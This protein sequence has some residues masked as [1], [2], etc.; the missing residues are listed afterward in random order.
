MTD[1]ARDD[2]GALSRRVLD[3]QTDKADADDEILFPDDVLPGVGSQ[4][5]SLRE[6]LAK[7]GIA[8]FVVLLILNSLDELEAAALAVLAPEIRDSFGVG[9][10]VIVFLGAASVSFVFLGALPMGWLADRFRRGPVIGAASLAFGLFSLLSGLAR[11]VVVFFFARL[12]TG[13]AKS[14]TMP[15]HNSL[16]A[17]QYPIGVRGRIASLTIMSGRTVSIISPVLV[18]GIAAVVSWRWTYYTLWIPVAVVAVLAFRLPEPVRGQWEKNDVLGKAGDAVDPA[19]ISLEAAFARLN[20]V[21]TLRA[22][23]LGFAA[24]GF[25]LFS[26]PV[27]TS[28]FLE[29]EYGLGPLGRG[30]LTTASGVGVIAIMPFVGRWFDRFYRQNPTRSMTLIGALILPSALLL[31]IQFNMPNPWLFAVLDVPGALMMFAAFAMVGPLM[32]AVVPYRLR[33]I[34]SSLATL[35]I[36]FIGAAGGGLLSAMVVD[37]S[38]PKTTILVLGLPSTIVGGA[39]M[40]NGARH[41]RHDLSRNVAEILEEQAEHDRQLESPEHIPALQLADIDFSYGNVQVLFDVGFEV[42]KGETL[43]LL[44]TNGAGKSTIL[45]VIAG[46]GTPERGVVRLGGRTIT[47]STPEQRTNMGI[48]TLLGGNGVWAPLSV[49]HNLEMGAH[50]LRDDKAE[51]QRRI[52]HALELF[53]E[54]RSRLDD[55]ADSL[56]GGQ[57]QMLALARTLLCPPEVLLIDELSLGLAP[58]AVAELMGHIER[59]QSTGQTIVIVEQSLNIALELADRAVFIEKGQVRFEGPA[60]ELAERDDLVRAVFLGDEGG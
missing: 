35:Y 33:G 11:N 49:R 45:R 59:L 39:F 16:I 31:P 6:G 10:G 37:A 51:R 18:G 53:P 60:S 43:A 29:D 42:R 40:L 17:D 23:L 7:G 22:V 34:G 46:L 57:Q 13:I 27:L 48:Q 54:L 25:G 47:F 3:S 38:G 56:S 14:N 20:K 5:M 50:Q 12:G 28:L 58:T 44:G 2:A 55:R 4:E 1:A 30:T 8:T 36:F 26:R 32:Q 52:E 9:D 21:A 15:V 24:L 41:I 19:P